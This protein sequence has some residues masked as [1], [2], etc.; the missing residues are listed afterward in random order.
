M[1]EPPAPNRM[2]IIRRIT[3][4]AWLWGSAVAALAV[5]TDKAAKWLIVSVV[6]DPPRLI[7]ITPFVNPTLGLNAGVSLGMLGETFGRTPRLLI[8]ISLSIVAL[9]LVWLQRTQNRTEA[10]GLGAPS[11]R[12]CS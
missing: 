7:P 5:A 11:G 12:S 6:M 9:M 10:S 8:A 1:Y 4:P 2:Q 3:I